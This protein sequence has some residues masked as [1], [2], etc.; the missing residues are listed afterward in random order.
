MGGAEGPRGDRPGP[1]RLVGRILVG[2]FSGPYVEC[3]IEVGNRLIRRPGPARG[4]A[5]RR[6]AD[7]VVE[8]PVEASGSSPN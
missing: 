8:L 4:P 5:S 7:V 1:D 6:S 2:L 3:E